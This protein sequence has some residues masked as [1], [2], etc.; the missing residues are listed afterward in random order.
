MLLRRFYL[1][2]KTLNNS[3]GIQQSTTQSVFFFFFFFF[4]CTHISIV[5]FTRAKSHGFT[6]KNVCHSVWVCGK[7][8]KSQ[9]KTGFVFS[10]NLLQVKKKRSQLQ[11]VTS[12]NPSKSSSVFSVTYSFIR[13]R[14]NGRL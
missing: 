6:F 9:S 12:T 7:N 11:Y 13:V 4:F 3:L 14:I 5:S 10:T 1:Q 8:A 2:Y